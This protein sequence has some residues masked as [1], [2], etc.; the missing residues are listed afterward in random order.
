MPEEPTSF[1]GVSGTVFSESVGHSG[2]G[3]LHP[4]ASCGAMAFECISE[5]FNGDGDESA[6]NQHPRHGMR[7]WLSLR[8]RE[9]QFHT[10]RVSPWPKKM[11]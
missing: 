9:A 7:I 6:P 5:P 10:T 3:R 8:F 2:D 1:V 11:R 4:P